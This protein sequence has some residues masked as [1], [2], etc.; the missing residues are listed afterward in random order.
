[1]KRSTEHG[2][3]E[4]VD[5]ERVGRDGGV[6]RVGVRYPARHSVE[7]AWGRCG[8]IGWGSPSTA[9][10]GLCDI[11]LT[12]WAWK[13]PHL[14]T[15]SPST[16]SFPNCPHTSCVHALPDVAPPTLVHTSPRTPRQPDIRPRTPP[17]CPPRVSHCTPWQWESVQARGARAKGGVAGQ[18]GQGVEEESQESGGPPLGPRCGGITFRVWV[19]GFLA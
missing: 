12:T 15:P 5:G 19:F 2:G 9:D 13:C 17:P 4:E 14:P 10:A 6:G 11:R 8:P 7:G 1:M 3:H 18:G 16:R